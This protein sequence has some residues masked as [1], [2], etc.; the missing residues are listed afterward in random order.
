MDFK[1]F[2]FKNY[3]KKAVEDLGFK[4]FTDVQL[5]VF[6]NLKTNKNILAK[7]RTGSGKTHAFLLPIFND[8]DEELNQVQA[9]IIAPTKELSMQIYK[10]AQ[11]IASFSPKAINIKLFSGGTDRLKEIDK[12][13]G[14]TP[15]IVIGTPGKIKDL[16]IDE[17][18]LKIYTSK[19]F[20]VDEVDMTFESGFSDELD[21][22]AATLSDAK[23]MFFSATVS[24]QVLPFIKKYMTNVEFIEIKNNTEAKIEHI[25]IPLKH[26]ERLDCLGDLLSCISP[27]LCIIFVNKKDNVQPVANYLSSLGYFTGVMHGDLT[28]RERKRVL[29]D[30]NKLKY[31]YLVATDLAARGI[32]IEGVTHI[33]NYEL[34]YDYEFYLHRSGRTGRMHNDG[35]VY[36]FYESVDDQYLDNLSKKKIVPTYFEIKDK[37]LVPY[38]GR[39]TRQ[40]RVKPQTDY[41]KEAAKLVPKSDKVKPGYKKKRQA[42][43]DEIARKLKKKDQK[44]RY[45]K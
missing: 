8:L 30:C 9:T 15:Q 39:N 6:N 14:N 28:P 29:Q 20:V 21:I 36:S 37:E 44:R 5:S 17:N 13:K 43:I 27:Y 1:N 3:I 23:M 12:L 45:Y 42:Q 7:S 11:H 22:I 2:E 19:Y 40:N 25:W 18:V 38:K 10:V 41:Q 24:E 16:A 34:P 31:Q 35:I 32:D 33:I 26:K 4:E